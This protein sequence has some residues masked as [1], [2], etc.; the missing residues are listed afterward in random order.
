MQITLTIKGMMCPHCEARVRDTLLAV[1]GVT[2]ATVSHTAG[3]AVVSGE[4][5]SGDALV[6]AVTGAGYTVTAWK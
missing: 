1:A 5:L 2:E 3:T 4:S 6:Q